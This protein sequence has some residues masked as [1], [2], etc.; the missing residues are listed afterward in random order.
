MVFSFSSANVANYI[1]HDGIDIGGL[2]VR[3]ERLKQEPI[4]CLKC[5]GWE[6]KAQDCTVQTDICGTCR[7]NHHTG[8]CTI[9]DK[10]YCASCKTEEHVS[11]D[12][13]C[14]EFKRHCEDYDRKFP[15]NNFI[16]FPTPQEWTLTTKPDRILLEQHFPQSLAAKNIHNSTNHNA[17]RPIVKLPW[18]KAQ[19]T[20]DSSQPWPGP[21]MG[22]MEKGKEKAREEGELLE[23]SKQ[24]ITFKHLN[25]EDLEDI[26][27]HQDNCPGGYIE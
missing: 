7:D 3:G 19:C 15:E 1:I 18:R 12:R 9:K 2:Q 17:T 27:G 21:N 25:T 26:L 5:R 13:K 16:Y 11:W 14:P 22:H 4:Q 20:A 23:T 10:L 6:H 24:D 8:D